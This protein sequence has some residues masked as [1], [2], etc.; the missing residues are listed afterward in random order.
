MNIYLTELKHHLKAFIFWSL[1]IVGFMLAA[2]SK[3]DGYIKA[4]TSV[5]E[6]FNEFPAGV[7]SFFGTN[8]LD[9]QTASGFFTLCALYM[10]VMLGVHALLLGSGIIAKEET[11][12]TIEFLAT[13]PVS[14]DRVLFT[15]LLAALT[16]TIALNIVTLLVSLVTVAAFNPGP[17]ANGDIA[18]LMPAVFFIQL[19][20]LMVGISFASIMHRPQRAGML[21][22]G[23]LLATFIISAFVDITDKYNFLRYLTPFQYFDPK[24][25]FTEHSYNLAYIFITVV[26]VAIMLTASRF[27]YQNRDFSV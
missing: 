6:V 12:K 2:V 18:F 15:K 27:A 25:I 10:A 11:D 20:F 5:N 3:Y 1:G 7:S 13:K 19:F 9:L 8:I 17:P 22:A 14:R 24:I 26:V 23:V 4:G 16:A 21:S